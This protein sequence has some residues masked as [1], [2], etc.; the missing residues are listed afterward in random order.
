MLPFYLPLLLLALL[1]SA[2]GTV[3]R[4]AEIDHM[5]GAYGKRHFYAVAQEP[6]LDLSFKSQIA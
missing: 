5:L 6:A 4:I 2:N 1:L 3:L